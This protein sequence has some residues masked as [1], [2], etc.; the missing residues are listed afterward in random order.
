[1]I[2]EAKQQYRGV[3]CGHCRQPIPLSPSVERHH[4]GLDVFAARSF[5]LRCRAC[6]GER[7]YTALQV[8]DFDGIPKV[9]SSHAGK[10]LPRIPQ[11]RSDYL[12]D[13]KHPRATW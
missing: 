6:H 3:L 8:I 2:A 7:V 1:M 13:L 5:T 12:V 11:N 10:A 9:R 4:T